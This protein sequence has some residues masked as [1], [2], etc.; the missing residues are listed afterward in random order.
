MH[1]IGN[2]R[3]E[4]LARR[5]ELLAAE[6]RRDKKGLYLA[7]LG[8]LAVDGLVLGFD[9]LAGVYSRAGSVA[10]GLIIGL[11]SGAMVVYAAGKIKKNDKRKKEIRANESEIEN[12]TSQD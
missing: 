11:A 2:G 1:Y 4:E 8:T 12:L 9:T 3:A 6:S 7:T 5:N 10:E